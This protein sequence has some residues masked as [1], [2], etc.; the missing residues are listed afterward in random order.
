MRASI[1]ILHN[2]RAN[3]IINTND[4]DWFNNYISFFQGD[5][6][7]LQNNQQNQIFNGSLVCNGITITPTILSLL[8]NSTSNFETRFSNIENTNT[9]QNTNIT[10]V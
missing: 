3:S 7:Y 8:S 2:G 9:T 4:F 5:N 6:R 10:N 1:P